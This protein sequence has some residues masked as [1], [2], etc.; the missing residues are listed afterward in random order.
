MRNNRHGTVSDKDNDSRRTPPKNWRVNENRSIRR[1]DRQIAELH[2][3][4]VPKKSKD[5]GYSTY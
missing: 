5:R 1:E 3:D 2:I 4:D